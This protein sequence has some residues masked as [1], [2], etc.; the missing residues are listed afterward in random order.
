MLGNCRIQ[1]PLATTHLADAGG[2]CTGTST[3]ATMPNLGSI[4]P[5]LGTDPW[6]GL[7]AGPHSTAS[8]AR[9]SLEFRKGVQNDMFRRASVDS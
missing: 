3:L 1:P 9:S 6:N 7:F 5:S 8:T 2:P 4:R